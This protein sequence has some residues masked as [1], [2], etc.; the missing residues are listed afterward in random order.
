M[1]KIPIDEKVKEYEEL[2]REYNE[3]TEV[4]SKSISKRSSIEKRISE[5]YLDISEN[6]F[7]SMVGKYFCVDVDENYKEF[8][9]VCE[10][11]KDCTCCYA[12]ARYFTVPYNP[13]TNNNYGIKSFSI[14]KIDCLKEISEEYYESMLNKFLEGI[15]E[16]AL[17]REGL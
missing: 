11:E 13:Y 1:K 15:K 5:L 4:I 8:C 14:D 10:Y 3:C 16:F 9:Y 7:R 6:R 17:D 2:E 12:V